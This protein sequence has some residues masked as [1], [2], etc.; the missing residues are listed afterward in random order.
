MTGRG[1]KA[2]ANILLTLSKK[3]PDDLLCGLFPALQP[4]AV[5]EYL[6][7]AAKKISP[8]NSPKQ[9]SLDFSLKN[10]KSASKT[11]LSLF[12]DGASRGNPGEAGAGIQLLND[13]GEEIAAKGF[14]LGKCTNNMA[15]YKAL[16]LGLTEAKK[17]GAKELAIYL[18][19]ELIV[20][21]LQGRYKVKDTKLKPLYTEVIDLLADFKSY[22]V[23]HV[24]RKENQRADQLA[25]QGID[26]HLSC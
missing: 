5:R 18:D 20:R 3:L 25:N 17:F 19:S 13:A 26:E 7:A 8:D 22:K 16:I 21:Q 15:E 9:Q 6:R 2:E 23:G 10:T 11:K 12:T 4:T 24:P 1:K 14:Y